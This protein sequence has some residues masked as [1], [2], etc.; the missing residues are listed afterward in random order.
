MKIDTPVA[1]MGIRG[2]AGVIEQAPAPVQIDFEIPS[3]SDPSALSAKFQVLLEP[4]GA[5]GSYDLIDKV[6]G[7]KIATV[8]QAGQVVAY[9]PAG[10]VSVG[11][12]PPMSPELKQLVVDVFSQKFT[13]ATPKSVQ[14]A[15]SSSTPDTTPPAKVASSTS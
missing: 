9:S 1:T 12:A 14:T 5:V 15:Q 7:A 10:G 13:D 3:S 11:P 2:T 8:N 6:S 4:N